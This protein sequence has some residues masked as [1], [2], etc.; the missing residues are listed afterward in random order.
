MFLFKAIYKS[1]CFESS[2]SCQ[3]GRE[4]GYMNCQFE[5]LFF[6]LDF[7]LHI[8]N[9]DFIYNISQGPFLPL[10]IFDKI[11]LRGRQDTLR[12]KDGDDRETA[13]SMRLRPQTALNID[14]KPPL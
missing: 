7:S 2:F 13:Q 10:T 1:V 9:L 8:Q 14:I 5:P 3:H 4:N 11:K 12:E 6:S